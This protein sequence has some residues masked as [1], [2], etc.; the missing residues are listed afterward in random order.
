MAHFA[1][2]D[3]NNV[4]IRVLVVPDEQEH[5]GEEYLAQDLQLGGRWLQT[6]YNHRIRGRFAGPGSIYLPEHDRFVQYQPFPSWSLDEN[7]IWRPPFPP[8]NDGYVYKWNEP[9]QQW[10]QHS[11]L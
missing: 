11:K 6:S 3:E 4:V 5:R 7:F 9:L 1:E 8:P 2:L 10:D